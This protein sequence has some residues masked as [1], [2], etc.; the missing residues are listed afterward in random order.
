MIFFLLKI[1]RGH[2]RHSLFMKEESSSNRDDGAM[3]AIEESD[4]APR[5]EVLCL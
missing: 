3:N 1:L 2:D 4:E 5:Y